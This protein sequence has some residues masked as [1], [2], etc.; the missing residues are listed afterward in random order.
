MEKRMFIVRWLEG[1]GHQYG[2][3]KSADAAFKWADAN[4]SDKGWV[5]QP[6]L[7]PTKMR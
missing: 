4:L 5:I 1:C 3:F 7:P 2:P 6:L